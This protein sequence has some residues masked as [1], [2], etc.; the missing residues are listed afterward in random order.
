MR[1]VVALTIPNSQCNHDV[2][3]YDPDE[4]GIL[5]ERPREVGKSRHLAFVWN[6][7]LAFS[8]LTCL[9]FVFCLCGVFLF[10]G[11]DHTKYSLGIPHS[12]SDSGSDS[13]QQDGPMKVS[14]Q[15][16]QFERFTTGAPEC[17]AMTA[18]NVSFTLVTQLSMD[19]LWMMQHHCERWVH[20]ASIS[21]AV[22]TN[23]TTLQTR[24]A[25]ID[26]GCQ[27][28]VLTVQTMKAT[29]ELE[30]DYPVNRLRRMALSAVRTSHVM[31]ALASDPKLGLI[32][33][34]FQLKKQCRRLRDCPEKNIPMMPKTRQDVIDTVSKNRGSVFDPYN[35]GGHGSTLYEQW[36]KQEPG[37]LLEIPC[38]QSNRYE[39]YMA[40]R[41]Y[42]NLPPFQLHFSGYGKNKM[43]W[44]M[45]LRRE[46]YVFSQ[47]GGAYVIHYPHLKSAS[48]MEWEQRPSE[49]QPFKGPDGKISQRRPADVQLADWTSYKRGRVDA[50]FIAFRKWMQAEIEDAARI[51]MC[52]SKQDDDGMLWIDR[53]QAE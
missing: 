23:Q 47:L 12:V 27:G 28:D 49:L 48:R 31:E 25:L 2:H 42:R 21:V 43:A 45:Q 38:I 10:H 22:L 53:S 4:T 16:Q 5:Q 37:D 24:E 7:A 32:I 40:F 52:E 36:M 9:V 14:E 41:Y 11:S 50:A 51:Q 46:G 8:A 6:L 33:P 15:Q 39:P 3:G 34:A 26:L 1:R 35:E 19:R 44:V 30:A 13:E 17:T 29:E 20:A 18:D